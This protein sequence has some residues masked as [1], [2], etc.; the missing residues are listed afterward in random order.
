MKAGN[1]RVSQSALNTVLGY[2]DALSIFASIGREACVFIRGQ[3]NASG[4]A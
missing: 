2:A 3:M 1:Y 4:V